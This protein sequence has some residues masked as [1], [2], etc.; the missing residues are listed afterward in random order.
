MNSE[1]IENFLKKK[2]TEDQNYVKVTFKKRDAIYGLF[3]KDKDYSDLKTKN[4]WRIVTRTHV[5]EYNKSGNM[6]LAKIFHG[7]EFTRL[8]LFTGSHE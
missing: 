5:D 1:E 8:T 6:G 4:F 2:T 3:I 7:S